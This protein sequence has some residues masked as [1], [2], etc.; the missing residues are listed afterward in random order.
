VWKRFSTAQGNI[1]KGPPVVEGMSKAF[2]ETKGH[3][4]MRLMAALDTGRASSGSVRWT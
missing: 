2:E 4:S 3:L 1:L